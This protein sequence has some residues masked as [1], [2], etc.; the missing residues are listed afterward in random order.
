MFRITNRMMYD[1]TLFH[2]FRNNQGMLAA[3]EQL[4]T[5]KRINRPSD[6]PVGMMEVLQFRT[7]IGKAD[8]YLR[9][10]D[11]AD[12]YLGTA[13]STLGSVHDQL[14]V[15]K[16]LAVQHA[17][18]PMGTAE[19]RITAATQVDNII[20]QMIQYGN[21]RVGD[22]YIF[23]GQKSN[24]MAVDS[25]GNYL[26]SGK[27][28]R[29][30]INTNTIIPVSVRASEFLTTDMNPALSSANNG[31]LLASLNGGSGVPAG[32]FS[33]TNRLGATATITTAAMTDL[34]DVIAA[35]NGTGL[36]VTAT[37]SADGTALVL[38]DS[39]ANPTQ[40]L[41]IIDGGSGTAQALGIS[42]SR[43]TSVFTGDD[44]NP[45]ISGNTLL[46]D[47]Y[48][49][50][51]LTLTNITLTNSASSATVTFTGAETTVQNVL[52]AI[53]AVGAGINVNAAIDAMGQK[54]NITS[55]NP[56]TVANAFDTATGSTAEFLGIGGGQNVI[57]VLQRLSAALKANDTNGIMTSMALLDTTMANVNAVRGSVG[58]RANQVVSTR[59]SVDQGK[60]ENTKLKSFVEDADFLKAA[61]DLAMLQTAYQAT[62]KS[63]SSIVQPSLLDF[64][65]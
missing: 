53:N 42:G 20:Q 28:L 61:S 14:K 41:S 62:L 48:G 34:Q 65:R 39:N 12:A 35:I 43:N 55:T 60:Y 31:T 32:N 38:T 46:S 45:T 64:L 63:S 51:G 7:D 52:D 40:A 5:G 44:L 8:Q 29:A 21:T 36:N 13:D 16:E 2:T 47:L 10:M 50:T 1:S 9:V 27:D 33:I 19:N 22:R 15:V 23:S 6:D 49:G 54:L 57:P 4:S 26:G 30:E 11:N 58:A 25:N 59:D 37:I 24:N 3:Q 56:A 18:A 17:G